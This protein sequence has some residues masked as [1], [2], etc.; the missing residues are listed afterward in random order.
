[1]IG[2]PAIRPDLET[3]TRYRWQEGWES[4]VPEGQAVLRL[5][6]NTPPDPPDWY[7]G[8]AARLAA[9]P[10]HRYPDSRYT[11]LREAI[12]EYVGFPADQI[13]VTA[14]ADEAL[15]LCALLAL[16]PG[17]PRLRAR[18]VLRDVRQRHAAGRRCPGARARGR[19]PAL[20]LRPPQP[21]RRGGPPGGHPGARRTGRDRPGLRSS[22]GARTCP[23]WC[24]SGRTPWSRARMSKAFAIGGARVGYVIAPPE[25]AEKLD[26]IRPPGSISSHSVAVAEMALSETSRDARAGGRHHRRARAD[27]GAA[28]RGRAG[29]ARVGHQLPLDRP[30]RAATTRPSGACCSRASSSARVGPSRPTR[31]GSRLPRARD[32]DRVLDAL[33]IAPPEPG[34]SQGSGRTAGRWQR[35]TKETQ[36][37]CT[38]RPRRLGHRARDHRHRL[39]RPHAHRARVPLAV[40][41]RPHLHRRPLGRRAPHGRGRRAGA[42]PGD[43]PGARRPGRDRPLR[44]QPARRWTRRS[45]TRPSTS[46]GAAFAT[47]PPAA[48]RRPDRRAAVQPDHPLLRLAV[49]QRADGDPPRRPRR[50]RPPHRRGGVQGAGART[51]R[52]DGARRP[53]LRRFAQH[54]G[55]RCE[56]P[57]RHHRRPRRRQPALP[58]GGVRAAGA[59]G[60]A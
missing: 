34:R 26:A 43:R 9:V 27:V 32:N 3:I 24:A 41:P 36:I 18:S 31:S 56:R 16:S 55:Q 47:D 14:G 48:A 38:R 54:E 12:G 19:A 42:R 13:V 8:A 51:A 17:R 6:Q 10:V 46:A 60:R 7:A 5:D 45:A 25:I 50:R 2:K 30:R 29:R 35:R 33:G 1:M 53:P 15:V 57:R 58:A 20:G 28:A 44:R 40:R 59:A 23:I 39:P 52:R 21:D 49:A 37:D 22:S 11:A 4:L